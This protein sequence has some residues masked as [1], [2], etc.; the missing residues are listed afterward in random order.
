VI[1]KNISYNFFL[2]VVVF[3]INAKIRNSYLCIKVKGAFFRPSLSFL[4]EA[5][6]RHFLAEVHIKFFR[7]P[8]ELQN[9]RYYWKNSNLFC[10][11]LFQIDTF[12]NT[13]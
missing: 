2:S 4:A 10:I 3:E 1:R 7:R 9:K 5:Q 8:D 13:Y 12:I 11:Y 6:P